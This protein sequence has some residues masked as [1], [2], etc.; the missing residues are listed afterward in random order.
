[1]KVK[2]ILLLSISLFILSSCESDDSTKPNTDSP[3]YVNDWIYNQMGMYYFWNET[4]P[5]NPDK[6]LTPD[7]FF[8]SLVNK[9]DR[10]SW[11]QDNYEE[12]IASLSGVSSGDIGFEYIGYLVTA[13][14]DSVIGQIS[15]IKPN[16][17]AQAGG[18]KRGDVFTHVDGVH[19]NK[20]NWRSLLSG[21]KSTAEITFVDSNLENPVNK[22]IGKI[23]KY[24]ENPVYL[25]STYTIG[26]K[27]IG[28]LVYNFFANDNGNGD[29]QYDLQLNK[30]FADFKTAGITDLVLDLR[31]NSGGSM[32]SSLI[33]SSLIVP[34]LSTTKVFSTIQF[35]PLY[36]AAYTKKYGAESLVDKFVDKIQVC[37]TKQE[38]LNNPGSIKS[39]YVL[40][41][42]VTASASEMLINGL[43]P[44]MNVYLIGST[45][46]GKNVG[47]FTLYDEDN[48]TNKWGLQPIVLKYFNSKGT[49][50]F[51]KGF[52]PDTESKDNYLQKLAL[53]NL[54]E[55]MLQIAIQKITGIQRVRNAQSNTRQLQPEGS[56]IQK[57][58]WSNKGIVDNRVLIPMKDLKE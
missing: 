41:S 14:S 54:Q 53:G 2:Y 37:K 17:P 13:N 35:N 39:L 12:L 36:Q 5:S 46:V 3:T 1:M 51:E 56:S 42:N 22:V 40:T 11:I 32:L 23:T 7:K 19:L 48:K 58:S 21:A 20:S 4:L 50:D 26:N 57:K 25:D 52:T 30:V 29:M 16:T 18:L 55:E 9:E 44:Y 15:Y 38:K 43:K 31:Y 6:S 33:L 45:T 28:Y 47:S 10:F 8:E 34:D 24:A 49:S 27:K